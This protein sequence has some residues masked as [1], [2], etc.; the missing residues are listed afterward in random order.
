MQFANHT[1][2]AQSHE[3]VRRVTLRRRPRQRPQANDF[4]VSNA[5]IPQMRAG[6]V[7]IEVTHLSLDPYLRLRMANDPIGEPILPGDVIPGRGL[8]RV[9]ASRHRDFA[10]GDMVSGELGWQTVTA[11]AGAQLRKL[12]VALG[13][14][15]R[16][17]SLYGPS[18]LTAYF[19][20]LGREPSAGNVA[21]RT[22]LIAPGAGSVGT[23]AAQ[24]AALH[25][26]RVIGSGQ[27]SRQCAQINRLRGFS[28]SI[29]TS[30]GREAIAAA[31][32]DGIDLFIDGVGGRFHEN[33]VRYLRPKARVILIGYISGYGSGTRFRYGDNAAILFRRAHLEGFLLS[34][35]EHRFPEALS[36]LAYWA[37]QGKIEPVESTWHG[38]DQ[39]P[40][41][42]AALFD[43]AP[44]GK[45]VVQLTDME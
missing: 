27:N 22:V 3:S 11:L 29:D 21:E 37:A 1:A 19:I 6:E 36:A 5:A 31:C 18:G 24:I 42:F 8:G 26:A 4:E 43:G 25:G 44:P 40:M 14:P 45:Q 38:L 33:A 17:L 7:L 16:H 39:A 15:R 41:G 20:T 35:W 34:D 28:A 32:P 9:L 13:E 10:P 12:D 30:V 2:Q 23:L